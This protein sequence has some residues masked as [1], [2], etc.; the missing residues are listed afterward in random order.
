MF[1]E[2]YLLDS[3]P[4][5]TDL[6]VGKSI[7]KL[8]T[9][10]L[11]KMHTKCIFVGSG[12]ADRAPDLVDGICDRTEADIAVISDGEN[13]KDMESY[14]QMI[15]HLLRL[16]LNRDDPVAYVGGGTLG[17]LTGFVA[18]TFKRGIPLIGIPTTLLSMIDASIGGKNAID[19]EM[20]KN[21]VG[22]FYQPAVVMIDTE[23]LATGEQYHKWG[24]AE[25]I[26]AGFILDRG[27]TELLEGHT[28]CRDLLASDHLEELVVRA[29]K[30]K[31]SVVKSD[32]TEQKNKREI[33][34]FGH[35]IGHAIEK[36]HNYEVPHG[37]AVL[38]GMLIESRIASVLFPGTTSHEEKITRIA[39]A[40]DLETIQLSRSESSSYVDAIRGDKKRHSDEITIQVIEEEGRAR[41]ISVN[42]DSFIAGFMEV[43]D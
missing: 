26:K 29:I 22:T 3:I 36:V 16:R 13:H 30:A 5:K 31:M 41:N 33:L 8:I 19:T 23:F 39:S 15:H 32:P 27:I 12:L 14:G 17:D 24:V 4:S 35:T 10:K 43:L 38:T 9:E 6:M 20:L 11:N 7:S 2:T 1:Q 37:Q 40:L 25:L 34:N 18:S 42:L 21:A 28:S